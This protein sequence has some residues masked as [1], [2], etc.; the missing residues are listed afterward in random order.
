MQ[1][2][3]HHPH[4]WSFILFLDHVDDDMVEPE[5]SATQGLKSVP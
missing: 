1:L 2:I 4:E 5:E 3:Y